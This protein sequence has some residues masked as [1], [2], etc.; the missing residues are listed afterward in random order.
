MEDCSSILDALDKY[1][2]I[3]FCNTR[4]Q[5]MCIIDYDSHEFINSKWWN[6]VFLYRD[7]VKCCELVC[8]AYKEWFIDDN[9]QI[10]IIP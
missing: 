4:N 5:E 8:G 1:N 7:N 3:I 10:C 6:K 2:R 9:N